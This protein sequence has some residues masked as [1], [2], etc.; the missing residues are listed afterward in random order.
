MSELKRIVELG[1]LLVRQRRK[2]DGLKDDLDLAMRELRRIETED[3]PELMREVGINSVALEDG[4]TIE[5]SEDVECSITEAKRDEAHRWLIDNGFGG[6]IKTEVIKTFGRGER[7]AAQQCAEQI[8]GLTMERVHPSTL[9]SFI[10]EQL[11]AGKPIP[12]EPFGIFPYN[13]AKIKKA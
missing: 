11:A 12:F 1:N 8:G 5:V 7:D 6:L 2:V 9:K 10:K 4:T 3:L 13:R